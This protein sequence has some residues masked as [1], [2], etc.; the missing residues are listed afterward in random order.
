M[1]QARTYPDLLTSPYDEELFE[2]YTTAQLVLV[3]VQPHP[4]MSACAFSSVCK[5]ITL[6]DQTPPP[7]LPSSRAVL[8]ATS[9]WKSFW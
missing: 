3:T 7:V 4:P 8:S 2:Y 6:P 5:L 9:H 1:A